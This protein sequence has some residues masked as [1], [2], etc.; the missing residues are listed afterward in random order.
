MAQ[1]F[2]II[3]RGHMA[4]LGI[5]SSQ[6]T[7]IINTQVAISA[8]TGNVINHSNEGFKNARL[9]VQFQCVC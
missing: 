9:I 5:T 1:Q 4:D 7:T 8:I 6:L 3:F 2:G